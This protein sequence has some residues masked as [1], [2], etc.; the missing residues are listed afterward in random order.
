MGHSHD[1]IAFEGID[2]AGKT[3]Q[4]EMLCDR[5][6]KYNYTPI[7]LEEPTRGLH[8]RQALELL[9]D[10]GSSTSEQEAAFTADRRQYVKY[11]IEPLLEMMGTNRG[12]KLVQSRSYYSSPAYQSRDQQSILSAIEKQKAIARPYDAVVLLD[13]PADEAV[14][15][16]KKKEA[17]S[18]RPEFAESLNEV[19]ERYR[20]VASME[21]NFVIVDALGEKVTVA[22]RIWKELA[23]TPFEPES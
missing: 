23:I 2:G 4:I 22:D 18:G 8:G 11:K 3:T 1:Y 17:S 14:E 21:A 19:R 16:L 13:L 7:R 15:R 20:F 12:F 6:R 10:A 9:D 5:L